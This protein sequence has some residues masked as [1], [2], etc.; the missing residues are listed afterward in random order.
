MLTKH[1]LEP[2]AKRLQGLTDVFDRK[3]PSNE[4]LREWF[5]AL[6]EFTLPEVLGAL[7][8]ALRY[9]KKMPTPAD[10]IE[11]IGHQRTE[12]A[13]AEH[14]RRIRDEAE[15]ARKTFTATEHGA[16]QLRALLLRLT[17]AERVPEGKRWAEA[18]RARALRGEL[19]PLAVQQGAAHALRLSLSEFQA[20]PA[21]PLPE[22]HAQDQAESE[23]E[24]EARL[25]REAM[26]SEGV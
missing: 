14:R 20:R 25:E 3:Q 22:E 18:I 1:D 23:A 4:M 11:R 2:L 5:F 17:T 26:M 19:V 6:K 21:A 13:D 8:Y 15:A 16:A 7:E 9:S 12:R 24:R 10:V